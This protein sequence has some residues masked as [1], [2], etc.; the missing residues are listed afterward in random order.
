L[1]VK[2]PKKKQTYPKLEDGGMMAKGGRTSKDWTGRAR[3]ETWGKHDL[4]KMYENNLDLIAD[5]VDYTKYLQKEFGN[6]YAKEF[7]YEMMD[8]LKEGKI[9]YGDGSTLT[10][11][12][13][14]E[15]GAVHSK[16]HRYD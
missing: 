15:L 9:N 14:G 3:K 8:V 11:E 5:F 6:T 2:Q 16:T 13:G 1:D 12:D 10:F 7:V 4:S